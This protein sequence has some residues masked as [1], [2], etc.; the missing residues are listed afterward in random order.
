MGLR[1][2]LPAMLLI[3]ST[4]SSLLAQSSDCTGKAAQA[5]LPSIDS[6]YVDAMELARNLIDHRFIINCVA[7]SKLGHLFD[8][9]E[10][11]A[12][13]RTDQGDF[14]VLFLPKPE[15]FD[16]V[17]VVEEKQGNTYIYSFRGTPHAPTHVEGKRTE[18]I[19]SGNLLILVW[20]DS[21]NRGGPIRD[22]ATGIEAAISRSPNSSDSC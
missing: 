6:V 4:Q 19:R 2:V 21:D 10:G 3:A 7:A 18:F 20:G 14:D 16:A 13:Y 15:T 22:L 12:L 1:F 8:D 17:Q 11:A 5:Q 9:Q